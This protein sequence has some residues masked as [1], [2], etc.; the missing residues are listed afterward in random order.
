M[1]DSHSTLSKR[2]GSFFVV[3]F[4]GTGMPASL[5]KLYQRH[6]LGGVI[7]FDRNI[8]S[9]GQLKRLTGQVQSLPPDGCLIIS[10]D[11]EGGRF[12]RLKPPHFAALPPA[13]EVGIRSAL[14]LGRRM[15]QE[16]AALGI[17]V[18]FA[19][20]LDVNTNP[21]NPIIGERSFGSDPQLVAEVGRLLF[22][23]LQEKGVL[24][25]GKH[26]PGHGDTDQDS[27][28]TLPVVDHPMERLQEVEL[29]PFRELIGAGLRCLMTAHVL[30][31][32]LDSEHPATFSSRTLTG[33]LRK[34]LGFEGLIV[35][36]D[37]GMA[38]SLSQADIPEACIQAFAAGCDLLL[39][40]EHHERHEEIMEALGRAIDRS[41]ALQ[42]RARESLERIGRVTGGL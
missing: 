41:S 17:N 7:L 29:V 3:G 14:D 18:D 40:C 19:P 21:D 4:D 12:Q 1:N 37:M 6:G 36:D 11:Q 32:A 33:L 28:L 39:V 31:P 10:I 34:E 22:K 16:L 23:G 26:F 42:K 15:G 35:T 8:E 25:C 24:A 20:V 13:C 2:V 38:G 5:K 9:P 27:H 30:Y